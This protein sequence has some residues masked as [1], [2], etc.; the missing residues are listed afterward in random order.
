MIL[1]TNFSD[2][3]Q[4]TFYM[5]DDFSNYLN[6]SNDIFD[7]EEILTMFDEDDGIDNKSI[8]HTIRRGDDNTLRYY[9]TRY[10]DTSIEN[11]RP[12]TPAKLIIEHPPND[13]KPDY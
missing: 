4:V 2:S 10:M 5:R 13:Y 1:T 11:K 12:D 6:N 9:I 7:Y 8:T 3:D